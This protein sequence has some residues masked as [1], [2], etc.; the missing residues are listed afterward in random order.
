[1]KLISKGILPEGKLDGPEYPPSHHQAQRIAAKRGYRVPSDFYTEPKS[2]SSEDEAW[3]ALQRMLR[4]SPGVWKRDA[5][6]PLHSSLL[7]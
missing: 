1:M 7:K 5:P 2:Y 6:S 4:G 3:Y